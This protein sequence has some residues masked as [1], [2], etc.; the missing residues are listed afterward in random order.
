MCL[1]VMRHGEKKEMAK[2]KGVDIS[3]GVDIEKNLLMKQMIEMQTALLSW[4]SVALLALLEL[5]KPVLL[6][7]DFV[8]SVM[9]GE[10]EVKVAKQ[11]EPL[12]LIYDARWKPEERKPGE[13]TEL[14][15]EGPVTTEEA[16]DTNESL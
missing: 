14:K 6:T 4:Q 9:N 16:L 13:G 3:K 11:D 1:G 12:A 15:E 2:K 10:I 7:E 8:Q 5:G